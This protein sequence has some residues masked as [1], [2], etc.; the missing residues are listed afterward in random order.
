MGIEELVGIQHDAVK[1][2]IKKKA[3]AK[4]RKLLETELS[5]R[6]MVLAI[7]E[8]VLPVITYSFGIIN[9]LEGE[10]KQVDTDIRKMLHLYKVIQI[11]NDV[12]RLYG[13]RNKGGR[14]LIS[15]WDS[16]KA[17]I[18]R[19][20]HVMKN[21][22][23]E[24]LNLCYKLDQEKLFS[25][26]VKADKFEAEINIEHPKGFYERTTLHQA[27]IRASLA[28]KTI[29]ER[30][31]ATWQDKP[32]HGAYR[33][34]LM[35]INA[36]MKE[37]FGWL[38]KCFLDPAS[39]GYIMAAQEMALFTKY[40]ERYI[41][42]TRSD[43]TCRV[44]RLQGNDET[45]Y[46]ILSGCDSLA[47]REY[48]T[49]HNAICKYLH[50]VICN[51]YDIP[52]GHNWFTHSPKEVISCKSVDILYDQVLRTDLEVG[53]NR[54]DLIIKDKVGK[55]TYILDVSCPCDINIYKA[56]AT[57]VAKYIGLKGQLQKMWGFDC[58]IIPIIIGGLGSVTHN[59]KDYLA[60]IPGNPNIS[61]CQKATLLGSKKILMDVLSR[62]R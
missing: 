24:V 62:S 59:L 33:R 39:E 43:S 16:F 4:L 49:R 26:G 15:I 47:K 45:I 12:D 37:S 19:I 44:C 25:V 1:E 3:K 38:N 23:D 34:Q 56:E 10:L 31:I 58:I 48:F 22:D 30:R 21:S 41:L 8:C 46:H 7:N 42:K 13:E 57:K 50:Y 32:Q 14:G 28:K 51:A 55:K 6:N 40:H 11:K 53:A 61:M 2:K 36:D 27:K 17:S 20:A 54:P 5:S 35:E 60:M 52:T 9:W 29:L 18:I